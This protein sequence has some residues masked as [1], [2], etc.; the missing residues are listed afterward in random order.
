M[1]E[2]AELAA[3]T[4]RT[5]VDSAAEL[6]S[7][8]LG[9]G[10]PSA[11]ALV[12]AGF[13]T[14]EQIRG[15]G[16]PQLKELGVEPTDIDRIRALVEAQSS[17]PPPSREVPT[18]PRPAMDG[19]KIVG[20]W[21]DSVR[22]SERPKRRQ[23]TIP[24]KDSTDVLRK[25]VEGDDRAMEAWIQASEANRPAPSPAPAPA[26]VIAPAAPSPPEVGTAAVPGAEGAPPAPAAPALPAQL[27]EREETVVRWLTDLL[28]RVKSDHFDPHSL[29]QETQDI[30]RQLFEER[31]RR[32]QLEDE[33][34]HVKRG[35]IAV[36]K[37]T[38]SREARAREQAIQAK[39]AEIAELRLRLLQGGIATDTPIDASE[40]EAL[41]AADGARPAPTPDT[42]S[43]RDL[44]SQLRDEFQTR[45]NQFIERE[46]ELRRRI[47]QL[48]A[49]V[50]NLRTE[51]EVVK[52]RE[53]VLSLDEGSLPR[54]LEDRLKAFDARERELLVRENE[55]RTK[56]EEIR[57][58][59]EEMER[60]RAPLAYKEKEL[61]SWEQQLRVTKQA[62][63]IEARR[64][65]QLRAEEG[66]SSAAAAESSERSKQ[67]DELR[68]ELARREDE[69]RARETFVHQK[70]EELE[71]LQ[72]KAAEWDADQMHA[73][74][75]AAATETKV[76][77]GV[78]RLDDLLFGG[79]P[80][81]AAVLVNGP[82]HTGKDVLA[83]LFVAEGL[84]AGI[85][86]IWVVTDKT[87]TQI[88][89][90]MTGLL[91][92]YPQFEQRDLV[93]Y[94]DL[95]S[96]TL[97]VTQSEPSVKLLSP[98]EKGAVDQLT[99]AVN[100]FSQDLKE[101]AATYRMVFETVSTLTAYLDSSAMFRL[102]QP[103]VGR[104]KLDGASAYFVL[105]TGMHTDSDLQTLEHMMDGSVNLK[106]D[107]LK[108]F[109]SVRGITD[110][111]SRAW[112]GYTFTKKSF[113]LGSFSLDHIR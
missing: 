14:L 70:M 69:L 59:S 29:L 73:D 1:S 2:P 76:R 99:N 92:S 79:F 13:G 19:D 61:A 22:R 112:I 110:A 66:S 49:E 43:L 8:A 39:D 105:E 37:Y 111:Q 75:V 7:R 68:Q 94:V 104:R 3:E 62:L 74:V 103:L 51:A 97:G 101:K 93:R 78:R 25:W 67:L 58:S 57:I 82:A 88:R 64:F 47:V 65:E 42:A 33:V 96:R 38:R 52:Q 106:I 46:T 71:T 87:Y 95:Y 81:G 20:R 107:Q 16:E 5:G 80:K 41:A 45:E 9:I 30:Q 48:E 28:D 11:Q 40:A 90:E 32:K 15:L 34:E 108:T 44:Q 60:K 31:A 21:L 27:V 98:T 63:E 109:L 89:E 56:F 6:I 53:R 113:S 72:R 77:T 102:L 86:A 54:T 17:G 50:R 18:V 4:A 85:P 24:A 36:I 12:S 35:S 10:L 23:L 91:P 26:S 100:T 55:L 83:R 84:K